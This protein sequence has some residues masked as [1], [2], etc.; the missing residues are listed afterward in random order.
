[1]ARTAENPEEIAPLV[2]LCKAGQLFAVQEWIDEG[3]PLNP[4]PLTSKR[5]RK[6]SPLEYAVDLGFHSLVEVLL[7]GGADIRPYG[8]V[9][10]VTLAIKSR[11][12]DM[13]QLF[14]EFGYDARTVDLDL[15]FE[16]WEPDMMR[17][18]IDR[19]ADCESTMPLAR[20]LCN[21][22]RTA[23]AIYRDYKDRFP[24]FPE[25]ANVA[26]RHHCLHGN[27]K[28]VSL[29]LWAG[30]DP[31]APGEAEPE[32]V[33][34]P[35]DPGISAMA[36]AA[37][38]NHYEVFDLKKIKTDPSHRQSQEL[39]KWCC[40]PQGIDPIERLL[41]A[42]VPPNDQE[43]GGCSAIQ[44]LLQRLEGYGSTL[45]QFK[46]L[47]S[48]GGDDPRARELMRGIHILAKAGGRWV[49]ED[50]YQLNTAR[51][52]LIQM[53]ADYTAEFVWIMGKFHACSHETVVAL[54]R[55]PTIKKRT[56]R[57]RKRIAEILSQWQDADSELPAAQQVRADGA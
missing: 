8:G 41:K 35:D 36:F 50:Q 44:S 52:S 11:R 1:M 51:R 34:T 14:V 26:L 48:G 46:H 12:L 31:W 53:T 3:R 18:F 39:L 22:I 10:P 30:A 42:G 25:Q 21:R 5:T 9:C 56:Q 38:G 16:S 7:R 47:N 2:A 33:S 4:P 54:L 15:V 17:Y 43:N 55:T 13:V 20:A 28:W 45:P 19:G 49:P 24:T 23:L 32:A 37:L 57:V 29:M 27:L 6:K 40:D